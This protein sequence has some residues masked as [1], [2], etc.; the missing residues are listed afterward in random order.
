MTTQELREAFLREHRRDRRLTFINYAIICFIV[1]L[2]VGLIAFIV[3]SS[4]GQISQV[5]VSILNGGSDDASAPAYVKYIF[6]AVIG[7][8]ILYPFY[9]VWK[10]SKRPKKIEEL[11]NK[12]QAGSKATTIQDYKEYK[13]TLPLLKVNIKMCPV[14][15]VMVYLNTD[16]KPYQLPLNSLYI[17]DMKVI[18]SGANIDKLN[19]IRDVLYSNDDEAETTSADAP[20]APGAPQITKEEDNTPTPIKPVEEFRAFLK[21]NLQETIDTI[22]SQR[23]SSRKMMFIIT[24]IMLLLVFGFAGYFYYSSYTASVEATASGDYSSM[25]EST[26]KM[27]IPFFVVIILIGL[28][29]SYFMRLKAKKAAGTQTVAQ[30]NL[31]NMY[32]AGASFNEI[33]FSKI[34]NFIN[35]TVEYIPLGHVGL[36]EFL[37]SGMFIRKNY[38]I[39]G[40][41]Q[42]VG[43]HNGVPFIMC[44][45][46][47]D[48]KR[49]LSDE[50]DSPDNV[51]SGQFF[52]ARFNKKFSSAVFIR[53][54]S[55]FFGG[56][57]TAGY[58]SLTGEKVKLEDPEFMDM[59]EIYAE[60]QVEARYILTPSLMER[61]KELAKRTKGKFYIA[62]NNN[63]ITV[64]NNSNSSKFG[65][66]Y[67]KSLTKDDNKLLVDFYSNICDQFA[68]ID[69]LKLNVKIW[70]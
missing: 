59:F 3:K 66:G 27:V 8:T 39:R 54:R 40:N 11:L 65:V 62:F 43:R 42:I 23:K 6:M 50:K 15:Y 12:I 17:P 64:Y 35:P 26:W 36:P 29:Y 28:G 20:A 19:E 10:L 56:G 37:E 22:D 52:V 55:G 51:F 44:E 32:A 24:P 67:F 7:G 57:D 63:K 9:H 61:L 45:L 5:F 2:V 46:W 4:G 1:L 14:T 48:Y 18:F 38:N 70:G 31:S 16:T 21:E 41:D 25:N 69:D 13:V 53:P 60:D 49:N 47:V 34:I 33:V 58:T 68:I 30:T